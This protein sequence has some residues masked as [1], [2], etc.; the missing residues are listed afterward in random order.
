MRAVI[1]FLLSRWVLGFVGAL[2]LAL[3]VW[4]VGA[5]VAVGDVRR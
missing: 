5:L 2:A 1:R 3:V 4:F